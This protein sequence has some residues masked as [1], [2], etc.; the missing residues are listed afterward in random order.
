MR[1]A[2]ANA[3]ETSIVNLQR[4]QQALSDAQVQLTSG[5]RVLRASDDPTAAAQAARAMAAGT[6]IEAQQRALQ[7]SRADMQLSETALGDAGDLLQQAR[8]LV[9][10]AGN[11]GYNA[12]D[13]ATIVQQLKGLRSDLLAV[14]NRQDANGRFLFGGQGT[15]QQPMTTDP[16]TGAV[17]YSGVPGQQQVAT[18]QAMPLTIDGRLA[19]MQTA[20]PALPGSTISAFDALDSAIKDLADPALQTSTLVAQTVRQSLGRIDAVSGTLA[21]WRSFAG[22]ELNTADRVDSQLSQSKLDAETQRS[23]AEDLDMVQA[24]SD[25]KNQQTGYDA[26]LQTYSL[27][28]RM[29]L[30]DYIK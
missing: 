27:V 20:D 6:R 15:S 19:W 13:R 9:V 21:S 24:V 18:S 25:F 30:F 28:Q 29:S 8:D 26:A 23:S 1:I 3:Y 10:G 7:A 17:A 5:K 16:L 11:G 22:S 12:S 4:R 14:A 2:T